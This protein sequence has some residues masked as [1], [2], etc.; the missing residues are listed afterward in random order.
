MK[1]NLK[2]W[3]A[4][5]YSICLILTFKITTAYNG[6]M[7][8]C[9]TIIFTIFISEFY[10]TIQHRH[11][12][13]EYLIFTLSTLGFTILGIFTYNIPIISLS[14]CM[15]IWSIQYPRIINN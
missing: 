3:L 14:I 2:I 11:I 6:F 7:V 1:L 15:F 9:Y 4:L 8:I 12:G 13:D 5:L 10:N